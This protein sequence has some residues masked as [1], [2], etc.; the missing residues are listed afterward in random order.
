VLAVLERTPDVPDL[1][2]GR[3]GDDR[4]HDASFGAH[5]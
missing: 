3:D 5:N 1:R 4:R 2:C